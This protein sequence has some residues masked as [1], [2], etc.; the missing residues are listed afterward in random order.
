MLTA[1][2][3]FDV[4]AEVFQVDYGFILIQWSAP[5]RMRF[6]VMFPYTRSAKIIVSTVLK[7]P[8]KQM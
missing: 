7:D 6:S 8:L 1:R 2:D 4:S 3:G 5:R